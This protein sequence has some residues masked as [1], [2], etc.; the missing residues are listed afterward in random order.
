M[1]SMLLKCYDLILEESIAL[2]VDR[3]KMEMKISSAH[4]SKGK[5]RNRLWTEQCETAGVL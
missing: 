3:D 2:I 5:T 4:N 1:D